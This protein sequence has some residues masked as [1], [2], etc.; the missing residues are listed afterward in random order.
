MT[1]EPGAVLHSA[2]SASCLHDDSPLLVLS[3]YPCIALK[4]LSAD[5]LTA[6]LPSCSITMS[7]NAPYTRSY[8]NGS[9]ALTIRSMAEAGSG[10]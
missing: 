3:R 9:T 10:M 1:N 4:Y 2:E 6:A 5:R 8:S 7:Q